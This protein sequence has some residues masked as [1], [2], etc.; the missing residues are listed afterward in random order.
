[1]VSTSTRVENLDWGIRVKVICM[2]SIC[3][4]TGAFCA[5]YKSWFSLTRSVAACLQLS[6]NFTLAVLAEQELCRLSLVFEPLT[7]FGAK[8][9]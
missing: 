8:L 5:N 4:N 1:M 7:D 2:D 3:R 9:A 6:P